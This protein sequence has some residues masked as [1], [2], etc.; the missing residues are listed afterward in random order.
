VSNAFKQTYTSTRQI[1][2][3]VTLSATLFIFFSC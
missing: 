2:L 3:A 1:S